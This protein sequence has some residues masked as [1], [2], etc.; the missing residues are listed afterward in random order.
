MTNSVPTQ[1]DLR[2]IKKPTKRQSKFIEAWLQPN[3][4]TFA[5][6]YQSALVAGYSESKARVITV[7]SAHTPWIQEAKKILAGSMSREHIAVLIEDIA[8][9]EKHAAVRLKAL[10][11]AGKYN[12]MFQD[13]GKTEVNVTF[14]NS[15]PRPTPDVAS[16]NVVDIE[17]TS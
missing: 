7:N 5:N 10:E 8:K 14:V 9:N 12:G 2:T 13:S 6:A 16:P 4:P 11:L 17:P 1:L 3:S 15:V